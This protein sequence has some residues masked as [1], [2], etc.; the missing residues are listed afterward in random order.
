VKPG[1]LLD[2]RAANLGV[3]RRE[4]L[5]EQE[6]AGPDRKRPRDRDALLLAARQFAWEALGVLRHAD[7]AQRLRDALGDEL[8]RR[9]ARVEAERDV[10]GNAHMGKE[11]VILDDHREAALI[12]RQVRHV[13]STDEDAPR[14][15][16]HEPR[17]RAQRRGFAR[18]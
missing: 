8:F 11:R 16:T 18:A 5:V 17:D 2:H 12:G 6:D 3:E 10:F 7:D 14:G 15:G 4:R 9:A 1:D 13:G